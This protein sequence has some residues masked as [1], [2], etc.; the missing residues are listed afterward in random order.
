MKKETNRMLKKEENKFNNFLP[1]N[2]DNNFNKYLEA[3]TKLKNS[4][5]EGMMNYKRNNSELQLLIESGFMDEPENLK[6]LIDRMN[7]QNTPKIT[8]NN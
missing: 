4:R 6:A 1:E 7:Q 5:I 8:G 2:K 3:K